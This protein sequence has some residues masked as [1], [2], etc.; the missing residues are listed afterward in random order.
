MSYKELYQNL[1]QILNS[2]NRSEED[3]AKINEAFEFARCLHEGQYRVSEEPYIVHPIQV[4]I[5]LAELRVDR[6]TIISAL[7]LIFH[8]PF[9]LDFLSFSMV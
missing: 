9:L 2:Q 1:L 4:A 7:L 3:I 5:I 6:N 8:S